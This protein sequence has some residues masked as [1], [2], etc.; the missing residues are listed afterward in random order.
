MQAVT[1]THSQQV[2]L[3]KPAKG[4]PVTRKAREASFAES[5]AQIVAV[6]M[7]DRNFRKVPIGELEWLVLPPLM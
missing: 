3:V 5:F 1:P 2:G 6:L 4:A 7:R